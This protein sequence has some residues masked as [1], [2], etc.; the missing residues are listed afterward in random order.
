MLNL[1]INF[2]DKK[3]LKLLKFIIENRREICVLQISFHI[4]F[5]LI[6]IL[7]GFLVINLISIRKCQKHC[8]L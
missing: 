7:M 4:I 1:I 2:E 6:R 5:R 3:I 8:K